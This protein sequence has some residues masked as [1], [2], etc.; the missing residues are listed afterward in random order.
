MCV[1]LRNPCMNSN[2]QL[3]CGIPILMGT[4]RV[5]DLPR[6]RQILTCNSYLLERI[7]SSW[8][9]ML[10][11]YFSQVQRILLQ[12]AKMIWLVSLR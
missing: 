5:W 6:V 12:G 8:F 4:C 2:R 11:I 10:M 9:C 3:G 1:G 7:L